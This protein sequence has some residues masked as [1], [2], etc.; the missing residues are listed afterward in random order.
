MLTRRAAL[1]TVLGAG[2]LKAAR[3]P[4]GD[5]PNLLF[6]WTDEQRADTMAAYGNTRFHVPNMNAL[7]QRSVVF[8]RCYDSQ[9]VCTPAR[10]SVMTG[11]WPHVSGCI[12]NNIPLRSQFHTLPE[13][14]GDSSYRT[15]YMGKWHLGDEIFAQHGFQQWVSVE[16]YMYDKYYSPGRDRS[17]L[18]DYY[19]YLRNLGYKPD[20]PNGFSRLFT[21]KL[22]IEQCK[23]AFLAR[24]ATK[25]IQANQNEPWILY[26]NFLEPH[27]PFNGPLNDLHTAQ[28]A[29]VPANYPGIP[30]D[31]E[32]ELYKAAR[33][34]Q[35]RK[36]SN[37][38]PLNTRVGVQRLNRN[39][40]GQVSQVDQAMGRILKTLEDTGQAENTIIV[41][42]TDHG[43]M[44]GAHSLIGKEVLYEEAMRVPM[45]LSVP[46]RQRRTLTV[47][48]P[49]SHIDVVPTLLELM[50]RPVPDFLTGESLLRVID[51]KK[52]QDDH[53]FVEW[54]TPPK[55]PNARAVVT[56]DGWKMAL[57][58]TDNCLLFN[59][60]QDPLEMHNLFYRPE[61]API[62]RTLKKRIEA[63][64]TRVKDPLLGHFH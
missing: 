39:Y 38:I 16:D 31:H 51:G 14:L 58:D 34:T 5:K 25:Y 7:A 22:P 4:A 24:H 46:F 43:E 55:G 63:W 32:P 26:V 62:I 1:Q 2:V 48:Q 10:S 54:H 27:M 52:R 42:T 9:P 57:Y 21:T 8:D 3:R 37:G 60:N 41:F 20:H 23:P 49:V 28:E 33:K 13:L 40:A 53:V 17:R 45:L 11:L 35:L 61:S 29:P 50:G 30:I 64:Q 59:R 56:P 47:R 12:T 19:Y 6:L 44:M 15:A 18:S 36:G